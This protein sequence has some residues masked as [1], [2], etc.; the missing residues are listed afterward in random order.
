MIDNVIIDPERDEKKLNMI[1]RDLYVAHACQKDHESLVSCLKTSD[2]C[3]EEDVDY[4][5]CL[6]KSYHRH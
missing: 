6:N 3:I 2:F 5:V 4:K 1:K